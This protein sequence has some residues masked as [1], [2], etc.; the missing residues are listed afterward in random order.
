VTFTADRA[1]RLDKFL[2]R[3]LPEHSRTRLTKLVDEGEVRVNGKPPKASLLLTSGDE[4]IVSSEPK[5]TPGHNLEPFL[6]ELDVLYEDDDCMVVNKPRGLST[7]P[8]ASLKEPSLVNALLARNPLSTGSAAYRPGIVHRL[9]KDTTGLLVVA[10][11]DA[12]HRNLAEQIA[13][14]T[15]ERKYVA[16]IQ[17]E[18]DQP[19]FRVDAPIARDRSNRLRMAIDPKGKSAITHAKRLG[20]VDDGTGVLVRLETGRTHQIRIHLRSIGHPVIGDILYSQLKRDL[21]LQLHA[22]FLSFNHPMTVERIAIYA[23]PP[24]DFVAGDLVTKAAVSS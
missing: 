2:A 1:E 5:Q 20:R 14:K 8:A 7:H 18:L 23:P 21:P 3:M 9:D 11:T 12:A 17:G 22:V 24:E 10:K 6:L 13:A 4:V 19:E 15:A 16:V